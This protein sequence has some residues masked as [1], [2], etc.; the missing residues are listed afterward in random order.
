MRMAAAVAVDCTLVWVALPVIAPIRL[1][2]A[3]R[4]PRLRE[5]ATPL[6]DRTR[7]VGQSQS[8]P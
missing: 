1:V 2:R 7:P 8:A 6:W 4:K 3:S 5:I